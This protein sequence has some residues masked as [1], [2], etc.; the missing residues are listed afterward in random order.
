N[1]EASTLRGNGVLQNLNTLISNSTSS[2]KYVSADAN[3][4]KRFKKKGRSISLNGR[5]TVGDSENDSYLLSE[6]AY[7]NTQGERD[8][9]DNIDQ[10]KPNRS[11]S[12]RSGLGFTYSD[13]LS[14]RISVNA[15]Y[16]FGMN[17]SKDDQ[18]SFNRSGN[19]QYSLL[20]SAFSNEFEFIDR[21][22]TYNL[23]LTYSTAKTYATLSTSLSDV[24]FEQT[25]LFMS[26]RPFVRN[27][28]NWQPNASYR[29]QLTK[30]ASLSFNYY[31]YTNQPVP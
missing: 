24:K 7:Y 23:G 29:Y 9:V 10:Y 3:Y 16:N 17:K 25:D 21:S 4:V 8:S 6:I 12:S 30:A 14:K 28:V 27:F 20:D 1:S 5:T 19:N 22:Q 15:G 13:V 2:N 11:T 26:E 31:G 18:R